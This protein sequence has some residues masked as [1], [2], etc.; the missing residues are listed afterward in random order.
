VDRKT[1]PA[2]AGGRRRVDLIVFN[3]AANERS[4]QA[5]LEAAVRAA[6]F[7]ALREMLR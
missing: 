4:R 5:P 7:A 3:A 2:L 1:N 6:D